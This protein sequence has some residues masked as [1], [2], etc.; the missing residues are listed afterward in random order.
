MR[1]RG[2]KINKL[3]VFLLSACANKNNDLLVY[4][5]HFVTKLSETAP[6]LLGMPTFDLS[7]L[8]FYQSERSNEGHWSILWLT[9]F[10]LMHAILKFERTDFLLTYNNGIF[11]L[12]FYSFWVIGLLRD[13]IS[14]WTKYWGHCKYPFLKKGA[15]F[16]FSRR[17]S[18]KIPGIVIFLL[19]FRWCWR[20]H[21]L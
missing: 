2:S 17:L 10:P 20:F 16:C 11:P 4:F 15:L 9:Y 7:Y 18:R 12:F 21:Q 6:K 1:R 3:A 8:S 5:N 13:I 14:F 19:D